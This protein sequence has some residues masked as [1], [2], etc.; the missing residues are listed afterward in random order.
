[1]PSKACNGY[2]IIMSAA[3]EAIAQIIYV[4]SR[5]DDHAPP[6]I[7]Y[8]HA[9]LKRMWTGFERASKEYP[10]ELGDLMSLKLWE[11]AYDYNFKMLGLSVAESPKW[12]D[13]RTLTK[14]EAA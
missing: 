13:N 10:G 14:P 11:S 4:K 8:R 6:K 9:T 1:M 12:L 7:V 3:L 2:S 5:E